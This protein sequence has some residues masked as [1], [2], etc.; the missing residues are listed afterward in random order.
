MLIVICIMLTLAPSERDAAGIAG[1]NICIA[2]VP[3]MVTRIR[4]QIGT[5]VFIEVSSVT[6]FSAPPCLNLDCQCATPYLVTLHR[7]KQCLEITFAKAFI[8]L[9]LD[10]LE[11]YRAEHS[12]RENL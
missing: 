5:L 3:L 9:A 7:F 11:E 1:T 10:E 4:S 2:K 6:P 12:L 8:A